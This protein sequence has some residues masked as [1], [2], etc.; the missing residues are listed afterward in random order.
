MGAKMELIEAEEYIRALKKTIKK[1]KKK[2][3]LFVYVEGGIIQNIISD[4]KIDLLVLDGDIDG[5]ETTK[6]F[7]DFH[8]GIKFDAIVTDWV[9]PEEINKKAV[10]HY[11]KQR[12]K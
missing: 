12:N 8:N 11:F 7:V 10:N 4:K 3:R 2:P 6:K 5:A 1:L 9:E